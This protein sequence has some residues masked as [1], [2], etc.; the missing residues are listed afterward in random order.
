[1]STVNPY[2]DYQ[3]ETEHF[4]LRQVREEDGP[5]L[6]ACYSDPEA[7]ARMN[8]DN[9]LRGFLCQTEEDL[10]AYIAIWQSEDYA[11]PAVIDKST[12]EPIG[13]LEIFGGETGVLRVDLASSWEIPAVLK[14]L[15]TLAMEK[16]P[17]DFPMGAMVTKA[18]AEAPA[19]RAVL[20]QL[21]FSGPEEFRGYGDYYRLTVRKLGIAYC[22]LACC[23]CSENRDCPGCGQTETPCFAQC[24]NF[25]CAREKGLSGCW[26]CEEFPCGKGMHGNNPRAR[27][28]VQFAKEYG[29]EKLIECLERNRWAGVVYHHPG[30]LTGDY[31]GLSQEAVF[32]LLLHGR[33]NPSS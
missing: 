3:Y 15:Y 30:Q 33:E 12:G 20:E 11:R 8:A 13:T 26:E 18:P 17:A 28:F 31:D 19:R 25:P 4:L 2:R 32:G 7:V 21:G 27:A 23:L 22:G 16:F 14:E 10:Q 9:C 5:A 1:M 29:T 24:E 6:M